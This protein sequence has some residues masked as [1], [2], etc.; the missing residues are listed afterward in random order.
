MLQKGDFI[1]NDPSLDLTTKSFDVKYN[2]SE[3]TDKESLD[4][5]TLNSILN[6]IKIPQND[7]SSKKITNRLLA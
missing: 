5:N 4:E 6:K 1:M 7:H 2:F 3:K